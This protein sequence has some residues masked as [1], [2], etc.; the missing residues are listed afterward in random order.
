MIKKL[1]FVSMIIIACV[2]SLPKNIGL[3]YNLMVVISFSFLILFSRRLDELS[4]SSLAISLFKGILYVRYL[5]IPILMMYVQV[6]GRSTIRIPEDNFFIFANLM[7]CAEI[8]LIFVSFEVIGKRK[9]SLVSIESIFLLNRKVYATLLALLFLMISTNPQGLSDFNFIFTMKGFD[10]DSGIQ[11]EGV[12]SI[13]TVLFLMV[14]TSG[15]L[16][17]IYNLKASTLVKCV[18]SCMTIAPYFL[19]Y[20]GNSRLSLVIGSLAWLVVLT[21]L[22]PSY[23]KK[24]KIALISLVGFSFS[25]VSIIKITS[26]TGGGGNA[27]DFVFTINQYFS[28]YYNV[29]NIYEMRQ[30]S[31]IGDPLSI[32]FYDMFKN[33]MG[34]NIFVDFPVVKSTTDLYNEYIYGHNLYADQIVSAP[35]QFYVIFGA[36]GYSVSIVVLNLMLMFFA[37]RSCE[38]NSILASYLY[39]FISMYLA[40]YFILNSGSVVSKAF[41]LTIFG[42]VFYILADKYRYKF[43]SFA[44]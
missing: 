20:V 26:L 24:I 9:I 18:L 6:D 12:I 36:V 14:F 39:S 11:S 29:Q 31:D 40:C 2:L 30:V 21:R 42:F 27:S 3:Y 34:I 5:F 15:I 43:R 23:D 17:Y 28:G 33:I 44:K 22:Y 32:L 19:F 38:E 10:R 1:L 25:V 41:N 7:L 37:K 4:K 13:F 16:S 35:Y 8:F